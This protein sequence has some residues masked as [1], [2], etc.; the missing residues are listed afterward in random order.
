MSAH[1]QIELTIWMSFHRGTKSRAPGLTCPNA[2]S[3]MHHEAK[4][5]S[6]S[7]RH[8]DESTAAAS[9]KTQIPK[10]S[11]IYYNPGIML[12]SCDYND[13]VMS[14]MASQITG[15]SIIF[16]CLVQNRPKSFIMWKCNNITNSGA[17]F[18]WFFRQT[19]KNFMADWKRFTIH[20]WMK[21][22][23]HCWSRLAVHMCSTTTQLYTY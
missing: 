13:V 1:Q 21:S 8:Q 22:V 16:S 7:L 17:Y 4:S 2:W 3:S 5:H 19:L 15:V 12:G 10:V 20:I 9:I 11:P 23:Y 6:P 14:A 18:S